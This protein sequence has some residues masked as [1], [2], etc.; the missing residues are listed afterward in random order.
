MGNIVI[1]E[2]FS[3]CV[4]KMGSSHKKPICAFDTCTHRILPG[5]TLC[6]YHRCSLE[7]CNNV[8]ES[9]SEYCKD[10]KC[11][12]LTCKEKALLGGVCN[13]HSSHVNFKGV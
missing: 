1:D 9:P 7:G 8:K 11:N 13:K 3:Y 5:K 4:Q 10:H 12:Y 6:P 2:N